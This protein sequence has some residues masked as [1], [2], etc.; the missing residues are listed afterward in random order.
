M[1]ARPLPVVYACS[2]CTS[3]GQLADH[4]ARS[5]DRAGLAEMASVAGIGAADPQELGRARSRFPVIAI[6]GCVNGC[7][8]RCLERHDIRPSR[9]Y[10]LSSFGAGRRPRSEFTADEAERVLQVLRDDLGQR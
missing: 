8:R 3:A 1:V 7:V 4:V 10:V 9:H 6:D 5:L 2:G